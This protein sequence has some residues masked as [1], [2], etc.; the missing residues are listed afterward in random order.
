MSKALDLLSKGIQKGF[1]A[2]EDHEIEK[3]R[4]YQEQQ[5][6]EEESKER[7]RQRLRDLYASA[8]EELRRLGLDPDNMTDEE[9]DNWGKGANNYFS[10]PSEMSAADVVNDAERILYDQYY[11]HVRKRQSSSPEYTFDDLAKILRDKYDND[12]SDARRYAETL[13]NWS[14]PKSFEDLI[15]ALKDVQWRLEHRNETINNFNFQARNAYKLCAKELGE[16]RARDL[17]HFDFDKPENIAMQA[18]EDRF[19]RL[20]AKAQQLKYILKES[21]LEE[22]SKYEKAYEERIA[23]QKKKEEERLMKRQK[24]QERR[25]QKKEEEEA[26]KKIEEEQR[27]KEEA[28]IAHQMKYHKRVAIVFWAAWLTAFILLFINMDEWYD[29][30]V[31]SL[32]GIVTAAA[33]GLYTTSTKIVHRNISLVLWTA[34]T[35]F[36]FYFMYDAEWW[37]YLLTI[38]IGSVVAIPLF[39]YQIYQDGH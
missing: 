33:L 19:G 16:S 28:E 4:R 35:Y 27:Q 32:I 6:R 13:A 34:W 29:Y 12:I 18:I 21:E 36:M 15:K 39:L 2:I 9:L 38:I 1:Q 8:P 26:R 37:G 30:V 11:E 22:L 3:G 17:G 10:Q 7:E 23:K 31:T 20:L 24:E 25:K 5:A 14:L